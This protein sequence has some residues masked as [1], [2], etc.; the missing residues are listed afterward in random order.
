LPHQKN[1]VDSKL[2]FQNKIVKFV[3]KIKE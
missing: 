1:V 2:V 3:K